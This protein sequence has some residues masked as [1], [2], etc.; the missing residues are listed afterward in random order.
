VI[1]R[2]YCIVCCPVRRSMMDN[3]RCP[4][5]TFRAKNSPPHRVH[6]AQRHPSSSAQPRETSVGPCRC[7]QS[8][9]LRT[10][11]VF[12]FQPGARCPYSTTA[13]DVP[14]EMMTENQRNDGSQF[15][16]MKSMIALVRP[17]WSKCSL[18]VFLPFCATRMA[19]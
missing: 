3:R 18:A 6:G 12:R 1:Y 16:F 14:P 2:Q 8:L 10:L 19:S 7:E 11:F 4:S 15:A 5:A 13:I 9:Q 17:T